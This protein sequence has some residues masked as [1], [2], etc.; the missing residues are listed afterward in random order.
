MNTLLPQTDQ[1]TKHP[2]DDD[3]QLQE[4]F[5]KG[6]FLHHYT[7]TAYPLDGSKVWRPYKIQADMVEATLSEEW[8]DVDELGVYV[9]VPFCERRCNYCEYAVLSGDDADRKEEYVNLLQKEIAMYHEIL[10]QR[11]AVGFDIG[12]GTPTALSATQLESIVKSVLSIFSTSRQFS[13]SIET[14]PRLA[15]DM[16][17]LKSLRDLGIERISMGVQTM[18]AHLLSYVGRSQGSQEVM[19]A[20]SNIRKAGF[21]KFN[22]DLMY[23]FAGQDTESFI[24]TLRFTT[25]LQPE[26][27]T[28]YRNRFKG[29]RLEQEASRVS[30]HDANAL[31]DLAF[32]FLTANGF[33]ANPG[34]N[35]F[36]RIPGDPGTSAYLT[37]RVV[38]GTPYLG[39]G[40]A[41][42][43]MQ[44]GSVSYNQGAATKRLDGYRELINRGRIPIQDLYILPPE[45]MM[46]KMICVSMYF[47]GIDTEAFRNRFSADFY[48]QF[49]DETIFLEE[50]GFMRREGNLFT[51]SSAGKDVLNGII[52]LFYSKRSR[53]NVLQKEVPYV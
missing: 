5:E 9:H 47:G 2:T 20:A 46:A 42:Q 4:L 11:T 44:K 15:Q 24:S 37:E 34:K 10:G 40:L 27:I 48:S 23:G 38:K 1:G 22:I 32:Q 51:M 29:T 53:E 6:L 26:Y 52:P 35:T 19:D 8:K 21:S 7:N 17:K 31:Y 43:S 13:M 45:E 30:L 39:L 14:T 18:D 49:P 50:K 25:G 28:L 16:Q 36:C 3:K 12:G 41:A 33:L